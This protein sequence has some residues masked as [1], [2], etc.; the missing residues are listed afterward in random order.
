MRPIIV[1][2]VS[3]INSFRWMNRLTDRPTGL[4]AVDPVIALPLPKHQYRGTDSELSLLVNYICISRTDQLVAFQKVYRPEL[5]IRFQ[6]PSALCEWMKLLLTVLVCVAVWC[7]IKVRC[8][9]TPV[10]A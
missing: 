1:R 4:D 5:P 2:A 6:N 7:S 8:S 3:T 9:R 10:V